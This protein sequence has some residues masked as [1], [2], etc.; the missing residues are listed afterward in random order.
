MAGRLATSTLRRRVLM[1]VLLLVVAVALGIGWWLYAHGGQLRFTPFAQDAADLQARL[2]RDAGLPVV[3]AGRVRR[4]EAD[5]TQP[6]AAIQ[7]LVIA[8]PAAAVRAGFAR[9]CAKAGLGAANAGTLAAQP[10]ALCSGPWEGGSATVE[11]VLDC[12]RTC[13][14]ELSVYHLWF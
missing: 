7:Q 13:R 8:A 11:L 2:V 5:G 14:A 10:D 12:A 1:P 6:D 3:S 9:A 4:L